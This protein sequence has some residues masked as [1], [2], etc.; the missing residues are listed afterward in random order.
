MGIHG[1][2][3]TASQ[4]SRRR[5][6]APSNLLPASRP[7]RPEQRSAQQR[8]RRSRQF[9]RRMRRFESMVDRA[10]F[11]KVNQTVAQWPIQLGLSNWHFSKTVSLLLLSLAIYG[12]VWL[13]SDEQWFVYRDSVTFNNLTYVDAETLYSAADID[14]WSIF[15]LSPRA[16]RNRLV[17]L[18]TVADAQVSVHLPNQIVIDVQEEKP[19]ALWVT[20]GGNFWLL[21]DGSSLPEPEPSQPDLLQIIDPLSESQAWNGAGNQRF[22]QGVLAS[23]LTLVQWMPDL[24]QIYYNQGYGL[25]FHLPDSGIWV[26]WGDGQKMET[27]LTNLMGLEQIVRNEGSKR[28]IIDVRFEKP[29]I[30]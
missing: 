26:Y 12:V 21:P 15:W 22:D 13:H 24:K 25:N 9:T 18:P 3:T 6:P 23:A 29:I 14:S 7:L 1:V 17:A 10:Q 2:R 27:K 4:T 20:Q 8:A 5:A 30:Q 28:N 16:I 11:T 19:I